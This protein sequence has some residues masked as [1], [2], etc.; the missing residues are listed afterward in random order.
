MI[1]VVFLL[2]VF[3]MLASRFGIDQALPISVAGASSGQYQGPP[4]LVEVIG[5]RVLLNGVDLSPD[6]LV[7][8]VVRLTQSTEDVILLRARDGATLQDLVR[9]MEVLSQAGFKRLVLVE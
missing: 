1:D 9:V 6:D 5:T 7:E 4:R 8:Q 2:L 3:F